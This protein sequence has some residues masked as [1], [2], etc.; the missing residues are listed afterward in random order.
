[1]AL[2]PKQDRFVQ[3][4]L[5]DLNATQAAIRAGYSAK[6]AEQQAYQLLQKT[7]VRAEIDAAKVERK[8][9]LIASAGDVV[10]EL[11]GI[12]V[13]DARE[14]V[15]FRRCCCRYCWG[16]GFRYQRTAAE[17]ERAMQEHS[18]KSEKA[19]EENKPALPP[20]DE[21]GGT[22]YNPKK[23]PSPDCPECFG[24]GVGQT[25]IHDTRKLSPQAARLY[26]G[27]KETKEGFEVKMLSQDAAIVNLG[28]HFGTFN[29]KLLIDATVKGS[30]SYKANIPA[31]KPN[32]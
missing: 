31:R 7:S 12:A 17:M 24:D 27:I 32:V 11:L 13:A 26:A 20:L 5:I 30:V 16:K 8:E 28:R 22:G 9:R 2:T 29:D 23:D 4:Y 19:I 10:N 25:F 15:E 3:E 1:M 6:T 21:Q 18:L 14:L